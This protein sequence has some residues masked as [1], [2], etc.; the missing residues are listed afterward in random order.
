M[1]ALSK[2]YEEFKADA[3]KL[4]KKIRKI[5]KGMQEQKSEG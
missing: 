4:L 5:K 3:E 1:K 2:E